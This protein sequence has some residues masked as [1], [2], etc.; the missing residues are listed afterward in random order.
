MATQ[1][2]TTRRR[3]QRERS[4][5]T[6]SELLEAARELFAQDGYAATSLD[7]IAAA[8]GVTKGA[9]YHHFAGKRE[10]FRAVFEREQRR[11]AA[12]E[13]DAYRRKRDPWE[14]F[15]SATRAFLE[16]SLDPGVQRITLL[17]APG[18]LG[19]ETMREIEAPNALAGIRHALRESMDAGR[20]AERPVE[21]LA[22]LLFGAVCEAA[23]AVARAENQRTAQRGVLAALRELLR[24]L[25]K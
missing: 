7:A 18:A 8:A 11:L 17:D 20:I 22:N 16:A 15:Y 19:W 9:V 1:Q 3:T 4:E 25:E 12:I 10:I 23:M 14:G 6:T 2:T 13:A 5:A 21:P 24:G